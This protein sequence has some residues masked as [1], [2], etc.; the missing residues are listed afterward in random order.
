MGLGRGVRIERHFAGAAVE[1]DYPRRAQPRLVEIKP[2]TA[3][4]PNERAM[5]ATWEVGPPL[6][7]DQPAK[8]LDRRAGE[9]E[10][11][12]LVGEHHRARR[13]LVQPRL[14]RPSSASATWRARRH[15]V[16]ARAKIGIVHRL[17]LAR[18]LAAAPPAPR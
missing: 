5:M 8:C 17:E 11:V 7:R 3:G 2:S 6:R 15:V 9:V 1:G 18:E 4:R 13:N 10:D 16:A 12:D 14:G